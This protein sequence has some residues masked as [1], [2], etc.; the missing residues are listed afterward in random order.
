MSALRSGS[1]ASPASGYRNGSVLF[2][3]SPGSGGGGGGFFGG[4][5]SVMS[6]GGGGFGR[7]GLVSPGGGGGGGFAPSRGGGGGGDGGARSYTHKQADAVSLLELF[8]MLDRTHSTTGLVSGLL[9][10]ARREP[11]SCYFSCSPP[12]HHP[13][14]ILC[15]IITTLSSNLQDSCLWRIRIWSLNH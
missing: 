8:R 14:L 15:F 9:P 12:P 5:G 7:G 2:S 6:G 3:P 11:V 1:P 13:S 10:E 4:R